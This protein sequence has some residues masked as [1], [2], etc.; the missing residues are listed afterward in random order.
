MA[1]PSLYDKKIVC[2]ILLDIILASKA[3]ET[4]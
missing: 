3:L 2:M 4:A 1:A